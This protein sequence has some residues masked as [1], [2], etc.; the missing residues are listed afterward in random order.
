[1]NTVLKLITLTASSLISQITLSDLIE[2]QFSGL[3]RA[4]ES[5]SPCDGTLLGDL[6]NT[7]F[8]GTI[9]FPESA[10]PTFTDN[11]ISGDSD[12]SVYIFDTDQ[13]SFSIVT[14]AAQINLQGHTP[15]TVTVNDCVEA[16]C[17]NR[18]DYV[19]FEASKNNF[20]Y[21]LIF[22]SSSGQFLNGSE[23]PAIDTLKNMSSTA[24]F[25]IYRSDLSQELNSFDSSG[26]NALTTNIA[27]APNLPL[28][29]AC[30]VIRAKNG[31]V[32][33]FCL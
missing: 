1:M 25:S 23:I 31:N 11:G 19:W 28:D 26:F 15:L 18:A 13:A 6:V 9:V 22:N 7:P 24:G 33:T 8:S 29:S 30:Y 17:T 14:N 3:F 27:N 32:I 16:Q 5:A 10:T 2:I 12:R 4:C 21:A 20:S